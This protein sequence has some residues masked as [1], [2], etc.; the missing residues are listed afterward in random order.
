MR[1]FIAVWPPA[2]VVAQIAALPRPPLD[3]LRWTTPEQWHVTL[4]FFGSVQALEPVVEALADVRL[5]AGVVAVAG[6]SLGRFGSRVLH[7]P[8]AGLSDVAG[9]VAGPT[10]AIGEP[11]DPRPFHGHL[12]L[13]RAR[14]R[15]RGGG[16]G[17]GGGRPEVDL[18]PLAAV[19]FSATWQ[20]SELTVV[21]SAPGRG[22]ATYSVVARVPVD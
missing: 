17:G 11:P 12:T 13:A 4:R 19:P 2:D 16:G 6:P 9:A 10:A 15:G 14:G 5:P 7:I 18:R 8:V 21:E 20:V 22:G 1:L 3:G